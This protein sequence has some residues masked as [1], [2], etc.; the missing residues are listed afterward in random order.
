MDKKNNITTK[1]NKKNMDNNKV[2]FIV[3]KLLTEKNLTISTAESCTGGLLAGTLINY[4]GI[5]SSFLEGAVTYSNESKMKRLNVKK[6][7][8]DK[9]GAV[10]TE[11]AKEMA[12]GI[13]KSSNTDIGIST[14]GVAGPGGGTKEKPVGLVYIG[15]NIH[16]KTL[17]E[18]LNCSGD[19]QSVRNTVVNKTLDMLK[20]ELL[21]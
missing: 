17:V 6:E 15:I 19:R 18:K 3:G 16:D 12:E 9:H 10:S 7:T 20:K 13:R 8:L 5:S 4:P 2:E 1:E 21:K 14:T 11:T